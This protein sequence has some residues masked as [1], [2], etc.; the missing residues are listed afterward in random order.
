M[1]NVINLSSKDEREWILMREGL[2]EDY[3]K[4]PDGP[5]SLEDAMSRIRAHWNEIFTPVTLQIPCDPPDSFTEE[6]W[7]TV[8][9]EME[10]SCNIITQQLDKE[11]AKHFALLVCSEYQTAFFQRRYLEEA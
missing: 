9:R 7:S 2:R 6:Q 1:S 11:R 3:K 4:M 10:K 8:K 5:A